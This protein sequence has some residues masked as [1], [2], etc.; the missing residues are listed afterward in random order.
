MR[1]WIVTHRLKSI[2]DRDF[3]QLKNFFSSSS[4]YLDPHILSPIIGASAISAHVSSVIFKES[5]LYAVI[6]ISH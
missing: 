5:M 3:G 4:Q 1:I 2:N 6:E